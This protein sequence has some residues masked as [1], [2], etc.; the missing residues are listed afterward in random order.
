VTGEDFLVQLEQC[1]VRLDVDTPILKEI[2]YYK[3][4]LD[5]I[6]F[7][8]GNQTKKYLEIRERL[9]QLDTPFELKYLFQTDIY[10]QTQSNRLD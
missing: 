2:Q 6:D 3:K 4:F 7:K 10:T 5:E 9:K 8:L 1:L